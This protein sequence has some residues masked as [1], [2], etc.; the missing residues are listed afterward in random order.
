MQQSDE[1]RTE[2]IMDLLA[3]YWRR[4]PNAADT[5]EG[6]AWWVPE[7]LAESPTLVLSALDILVARKI[8]HKQQRADGT[9][10]YSAQKTTPP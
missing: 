1:D 10:I 5:V 7:L 2:W 8:A 4:Y 6:V 3:A 9:V